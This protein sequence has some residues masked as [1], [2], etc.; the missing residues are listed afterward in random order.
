MVVII[1]FIVLAVIVGLFLGNEKGKYKKKGERGPIKG[2]RILT[3][4]EQPTFLKLREALPEHFVLAQV[5]YS[6]ER[7]L[8]S[9]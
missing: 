5:A 6:T 1:A 3:M 7:L 2:K 9:S 4:N 8:I